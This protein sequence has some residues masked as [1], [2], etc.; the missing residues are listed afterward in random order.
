M[1][2]ITKAFKFW[3]IQVSRGY[4]LPM[5][6]TNW[7]V[8]F[9]LGISN[10]GNILYGIL[11]LIG[12]ASAHMGTNVFDDF[13]DQIRK[14]PKQEC[15]STH[16]DTGE[17]NLKTIFFIALGYFIFALIIGVYLFVK[18]G[19]LVAVLAATGGIIALIY[20]FLN[21][22]SLGEIAVGLTFGP[23]LFAGVDFVMTGRI[24]LQALLLSIP[25]AIFT[26]VV[27]LVHALMDYDFDKI[28]GKKTLCILAGSKIAAL[29][30]IFGFIILA[31]A[32]TLGLI[33]LNYLPLE[34]GAVFGT[35]LI[36]ITL[37]KRLGLYITEKEHKKD[38][39]RTNFALAR[40]IGNI[41]CLV[42]AA[43]I[44]IEMF[45]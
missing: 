6:I 31:F 27:L 14:V 9:A 12:F 28:S 4:T 30:V 13:V 15:K 36:V 21:K 7:L 41:Y 39:F 22:F 24:S 2:K 17:T 44:L 34:A 42:V 20:P 16:L 5:S 29:N 23:L 40:N 10:N 26:V 43:S 1:N 37:H 11:A 45:I 18:C 38:D 32:L 19:W 8:V 3:F 35:I 25:I 33:G